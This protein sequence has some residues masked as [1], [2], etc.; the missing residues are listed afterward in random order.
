MS[1]HVTRQER[2]RAL[3][4]ASASALLVALSCAARA[5]TSGLGAAIELVDP[6]TL[7]VCADPSSLPFSNEK[8]E[9]YENKLAEFLAGKLGKKLSYAF[10]PQVVGFVRNTLAANTCDVIMSYVQGDRVVQNT[11]AY[12]QTAYALVFK[13]GHG[14]DG[15]ESLSDARLKGKHI[16]IVAA[17]PPA[18]IMARNGLMATARPYPLMVDTR[19]GTSAEAMIRDIET[20]AIDAGVLWGPIAG[21]YARKSTPPLT[22]VLLLNEQ[23]GPRMVFR[24]TMGVRPSDQE[25]KRELNRLIKE[26]Q[27]EIN[28][29]LLSFGVPLLDDNNKPIVQ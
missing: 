3:A 7:R 13:P 21:Y 6:K 18:T 22:M 27:Q 17:T 24:I 4:F 16:G 12:Y 5:Q 10:F 23:G 29:I 14:L 11:N 19:L 9:G 25:W 2:A 28:S 20:D 1:R 8:G 26:N 15:V